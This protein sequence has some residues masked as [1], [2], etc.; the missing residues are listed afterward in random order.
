MTHVLKME[1]GLVNH[2]ADAWRDSEARRAAKA[3]ARAAT[4]LCTRSRPRGRSGKFKNLHGSLM[5]AAR[6]LAA[7][8][9]RTT[10]SVELKVFL[11][12]TAC[13]VDRKLLNLVIVPRQESIYYRGF[14]R[15]GARV[16]VY[17]IIVVP[18]R[19]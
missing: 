2:F 13:T 12:Q 3:V 14:I 9:L 6:A 17:N 10:Q 19:Y 1:M 15:K 8:R 5:R 7:T 16:L 18:Q 4:R 11:K